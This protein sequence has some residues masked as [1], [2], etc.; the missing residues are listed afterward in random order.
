MVTTVGYREE[1]NRRE[2][3]ALRKSQETPRKLIDDKREPAPWCE[4]A[5]GM[6]FCC[7]EVYRY[8]R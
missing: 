7:V 6:G 2:E 5:D 3:T 1:E 4:F 8:R